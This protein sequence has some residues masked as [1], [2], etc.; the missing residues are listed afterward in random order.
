MAD[1]KPERI[2]EMRLKNCRRDISNIRRKICRK[3][4]ISPE[5]STLTGKLDS[6]RARIS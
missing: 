5:S 3:F 4:G 2:Q 6:Y 1:I